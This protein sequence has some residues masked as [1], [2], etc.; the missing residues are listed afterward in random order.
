MNVNI[1]P[2]WYSNSVSELYFVAIWDWVRWVASQTFAELALYAVA[3]EYHIHVQQTM[4]ELV[5]YT[6]ARECHMYNKL[7]QNLHCIQWPENT[8]TSYVWTVCSSQRIPHVQ[9]TVWTCAVCSSERIPHVQQ[10]IHH[11]MSEL[12]AVAREY[13]MYN[14][15]C[16]ILFRIMYAVVRV[17]SNLEFYAQLWPEN[18]TWITMSAFKKCDTLILSLVTRAKEASL[19][20]PVIKEQGYY[21]SSW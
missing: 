15:K 8:T 11:Y 6:I 17:G 18:T 7:C 14:N 16:L 5:L 21:C 10:T 20:V 4:S 1:L 9:Q 2:I 19:K 13:H 12:Y 3:R